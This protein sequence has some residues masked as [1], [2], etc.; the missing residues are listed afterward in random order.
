MYNMVYDFWSNKNRY[1]NIF[2]VRKLSMFINNLS[3]MV[4]NSIHW[5]KANLSFTFAVAKP[6][7]AII[8][9]HKRI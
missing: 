2:I 3:T 8:A 5:V 6:T 7:N 9:I 4:F 1:I